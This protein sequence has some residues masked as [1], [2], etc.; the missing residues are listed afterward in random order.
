MP[1]FA[2]HIGGSTHEHETRHYSHLL[3]L[4]CLRFA[5]CRIHVIPRFGGGSHSNKIWRLGLVISGCRNSHRHNYSTPITHSP[6]EGRCRS[7]RHG[8][9][10]SSLSGWMNTSCPMP[11][12]QDACLLYQRGRVQL[13]QRKC[14]T[15][16][17]D[18]RGRRGG[19]SC[20]NLLSLRT[21]AAPGFA[22]RLRC[23]VPSGSLVM[24]AG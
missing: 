24:S 5:E 10:R 16:K 15:D 3:A 9:L 14:K 19:N 21:C 17:D 11:Q 7:R 2:R 6:Q 1:C 8:S 20:Q 13:V 12:A 22:P 4:W 18:A 23:T